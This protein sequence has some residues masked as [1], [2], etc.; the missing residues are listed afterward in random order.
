MYVCYNKTRKVYLKCNNS[1][2]WGYAIN[3]SEAK[4]LATTSRF[5]WPLKNFVNIGG[6]WEYIDTDTMVSSPTT[7]TQSP[8]SKSPAANIEVGIGLKKASAG[9]D[10][11]LD[12]EVEMLINRFRTLDSTFVSECAKG[13]TEQLALL[14]DVDRRL[15]DIE[16]YIEF[17]RA[18]ACT[19]YKAFAL[20]QKL[21][22]MRRVIKDKIYIY[23]GMLDAKGTDIFSGKAIKKIEQDLRDRHYNPREVEGLFDRK[24]VRG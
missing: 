9:T 19:G 10:F 23:S 11:P 20:Q 6:E 13:K 15:V 22:R 16:H 12:S 1:G 24:K 17:I 2:C 5:E 8:S 4:K 21:L 3:E 7:V 18:D 14:S